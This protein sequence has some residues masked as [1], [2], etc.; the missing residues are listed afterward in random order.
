MKV[1]FTNFPL[2]NQSY[3]YVAIGVDVWRPDGRCSMLSR[4]TYLP[5]IC[6][7]QGARW[8]Q[9][10]K[11]KFI[12]LTILSYYVLLPIAKNKIIMTLSL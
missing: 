7:L 4:G 9:P 5:K 2:A 8:C 3:L 12:S 1:V 10:G 6:A 11:G